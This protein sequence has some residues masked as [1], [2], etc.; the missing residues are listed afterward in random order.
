MEKSHLSIGRNLSIVVMTLGNNGVFFI[1]CVCPATAIMLML[2]HRELEFEKWHCLIYWLAAVPSF[3][4]ISCYVSLVTVRSFYRWKKYK[5]GRIFRHV[6]T[7]FVPPFLVP[8]RIHVLGP[9]EL[10]M[11]FFLFN[12]SVSYPHSSSLSLYCCSAWPS[13]MSVLNGQCKSQQPAIWNFED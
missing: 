5:K 11:S 8:T 6:P 12:S 2:L 7:F 4:W 10:S 13:Q 3:V 9:L 1:S